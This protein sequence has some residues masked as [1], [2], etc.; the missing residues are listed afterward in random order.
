VDEVG[1]EVVIEDAGANLQ[2]EAGRS[3]PAMKKTLAREGRSEGCPGFP[4]ES[5][6]LCGPA[7]ITENLTTY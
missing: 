2:E 5:N 1:D 3:P 6:G 7:E 4:C